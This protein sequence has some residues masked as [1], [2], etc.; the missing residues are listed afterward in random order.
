MIMAADLYH[1]ITL[2]VNYGVCQAGKQPRLIN[3]LNIHIRHLCTATRYRTGNL[4][5]Q[6]L[7]IESLTWS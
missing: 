5:R 4:S 1:T 6:F 3:E 7:L 2:I